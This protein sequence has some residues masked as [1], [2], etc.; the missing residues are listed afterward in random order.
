MTVDG[1]GTLR[2]PG[3]DLECL[4]Q[5]RDYTDY[6]YKEFFYY[7]REGVLLVVTDVSINEPDTGFV[8]GDYEVMFS[9]NFPSVVK[10]ENNPLEFSLEQNYPNP[11]NPNTII[12]F[13]IP[14]RANV[15]L[16]VYDV[17]GNELVTLIN[18]ETVAGSYN[19]SF[20]ANGLSTGVYFY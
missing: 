1:Y 17:L 2:L 14:E 16:K 19:I 6:G 7:T 5:K 13:S 11:F 3:R 18:E 9:S 10:Q 12:S 4:R 8:N 20:N 15:N